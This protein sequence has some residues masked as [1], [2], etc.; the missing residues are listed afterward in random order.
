L[1]RLREACVFYLDENLCNCKPIEEVFKT[2]QLRYEKH[3][4]YFTRG[5]PD[6]DWLAFV[7]ERGWI[8]LTKDKGQRY[9][10]LEKKE[11]QTYQIKQFAF[12]SGNLSGAEMAEILGQNLRKI[13][14]IIEKHPPPFVAS[15]T[16]SGVHAKTLSSD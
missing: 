6:P 15:L 4:T 14:N 7:G 9:S 5:T 1:Q 13:F 12:H 3:L 2:A 16:R 8:V 10:P 11:L